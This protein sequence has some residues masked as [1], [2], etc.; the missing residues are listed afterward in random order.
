MRFILIILFIIPLKSEWIEPILIQ[1]VN[2]PFDDYGMIYNSHLDKYFFTSEKSGKAF[3]Y[4]S[5]DKGFI[6]VKGGINQTSKNQLY[7][8][9]LGE[10][11][12]IFSSF[13]KSKRQSFQNLFESNYQKQSWIK[14]S[15]IE[16]LSGNYFVSHPSISED[17]SMM[18]FSSNM[19]NTIYDT[20]LFISYLNSDGTWGNPLNLEE[21]NSPGSEI[22]PYLVSNDSLLFAS[23]GQGGEGGYDIFLSVKELGV[24]QRPIPITNINSPYNDSDPSIDKTGNLIFASDRPGGIGGLDLYKS[25][26]D[27]KSILN[28]TKD[29]E[30]KNY[31]FECVY[32]KI[33]A[34]IEEIIEFIV[35]PDNTLKEVTINRN[36]DFFPK[37]LPIRFL[38]LQKDEKVVADYKLSSQRNTFYKSEKNEITKEL[39]LF[40]EQHGDQLSKYD[41]IKI[42]ITVESDKIIE[43]NK[44]LDVNKQITKTPNELNIN[45]QLYNFIQVD[46]DYL[47]FDKA[48]IQLIKGFIIINNE[49][50]VIRYNAS[51]KLQ[52]ER[53]SDFLRSEGKQ[54]VLI[55]DSD[56]IL[57]QILFKKIQ[58]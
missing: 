55:E 15:L 33:N 7:I 56:V 34:E 16:E 26:L 42:M 2:S 5:N 58:L 46:E 28:E 50:I 12:A 11:K 27:N 24:W 32:N 3:F 21:I 18:I 43:F 10:R 54:C 13:R 39:V 8:S 49:S 6:T 48:F 52:A 9:F 20:D 31:E 45:D 29:N 53:I 1:G 47:V 41:N 57:T 35:L 30:D 51:K 14:G 4:E 36:I 40:P 38:W 23:D 25:L 44:I 19:N 37:E 22:T 17:G